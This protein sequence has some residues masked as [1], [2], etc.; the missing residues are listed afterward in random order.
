M[1][2]VTAVKTVLGKY[3]TFSGRAARPEYWWW[4]L[5]TVI[6]FFVLGLIDGAL[7]APMMGFEAFE[8]NAGQPLSVIASL[9]L[10]VPNLAVAARRLHDTDRSGWWLLLG[11]IPLIGSLIL[12]YFLVQKGTEGSNRFG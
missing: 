2:M 9:A 8:P 7:V 11:L 3:A 12:I 1:D 4:V 5:A 6:L 10:L